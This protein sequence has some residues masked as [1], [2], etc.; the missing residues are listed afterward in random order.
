LTRRHPNSALNPPP[1][2][3]L[4]VNGLI[5]FRAGKHTDD[6]GVAIGSPYHMPC[7]WNEFAVI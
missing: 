4:L 7:V 1:G 2:E 3:R 5:R 6:V